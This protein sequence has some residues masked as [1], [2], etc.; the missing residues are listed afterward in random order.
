M[1][2][3]TLILEYLSKLPLS[4]ELHHHAPVRTMD[5]CLSLPF[6]TEDIVFCKNILLT[7]RQKDAFFLFLTLP[8]KPFRT[9]E[10]SKKLGTSRL[11]FAPSDLLPE[12]LQLESGSLSPLA[13]WLDKNH[14]IMLVLDRDIYAYPR[15]ALHPCDHTAS[16]VLRMEDFRQV[17]VPSLKAIVTELTLPVPS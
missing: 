9:A 5:D 12:L 17:V 14:R 10:V 11:S 1:S 4:Y 8:H 13:L 6:I 2:Q 15:L 16:V 7:T 3:Q